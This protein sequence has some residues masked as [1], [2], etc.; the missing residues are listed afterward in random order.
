M[1]PSWVRLSEE[2]GETEARERGWGVAGLR[3]TGGA[4]RRRGAGRARLLEGGGTC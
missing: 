1:S 4:A 3:E 2:E